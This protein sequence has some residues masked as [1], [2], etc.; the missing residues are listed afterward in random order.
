LLAHW[1][2]AKD[3]LLLQTL[4]QPSAN[5]CQRAELAPAEIFTDVSHPGLLCPAVHQ[6]QLQGPL[7]TAEDLSISDLDSNNDLKS[8]LGFILALPTCAWK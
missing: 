6:Q 3:L 4:I 2:T 1:F 7:A 8:P 5:K